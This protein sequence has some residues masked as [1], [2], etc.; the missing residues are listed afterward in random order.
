MREYK[1]YFSKNKFCKKVHKKVESLRKNLTEKNR[2][3]AK[4]IKYE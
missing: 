4:K 1:K 3:N 2:K